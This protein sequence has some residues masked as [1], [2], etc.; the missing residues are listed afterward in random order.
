[1]HAKIKIVAAMLIFGSIGAFVR[2]INLS[3]AEIAF[4][5][6]AIGSIFLIGAGF[7]LRQ[8]FSYNL[9][10]KNLLLL[11]LSGAALGINWIFLFQA[12]EYTSIA[13]ATLSYYFAPV[14]V[15]MLAP[16]IL[17]ETLTPLKI[18][19]V[20]VAMFGLFLIVGVSNG[21]SG[22][23]FNYNHTAGVIYGLLA[24]ALYAG[25]ILMNKFIKNLSG[26]ETTLIQL[27]CAVLVL[28]PY[29]ALRKGLSFSGIESKA[30]LLILIVGII[31]TGVVYFLY[32]T[33][34]KDLKGQTIAVWSYID[35]ISAVVIAAIF[36][37]EA[38]NFMQII[39]GVCI[40][41]STCLSER[42]EKA[43]QRHSL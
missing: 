8:R 13:N 21:H 9:I 43:G 30:V 3:P 41:G 6:A 32:F 14:L 2:H 39:G 37:G 27:I 19:C 25:V 31:H 15:I 16:F 23:I 42:L 1:M 4:L 22:Y 17:K 12:Y 5:R 28:L 38:M 11:V 10:K 29:V 18:I 24:A 33:A 34:I 35:P 20:F 36:L 40:L 26:F 7:F